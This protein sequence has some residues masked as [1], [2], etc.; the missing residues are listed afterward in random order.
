MH[1]V[2]LPVFPT[3]QIEFAVG[4]FFFIPLRCLTIESVAE[5]GRVYFIDEEGRIVA[6]ARRQN[7]E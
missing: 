7:H 6:V 1:R 4:H 2:V 3:M 5:T